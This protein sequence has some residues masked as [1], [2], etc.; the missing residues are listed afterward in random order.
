[1]TTTETPF[2]TPA[3][4]T[5]GT[6]Y[7]FGLLGQGAEETR[8]FDPT[9]GPLYPW[10]GTGVDFCPAF[11]YSSPQ[12]KLKAPCRLAITAT[13]SPLQSAGQHARLAAAANLAFWRTRPRST[14]SNRRLRPKNPMFEE[15]YYIDHEAASPPSP[16]ASS[17]INS[18]PTRSLWTDI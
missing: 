1:M 9:A 10:L 7:W 18:A 2:L 8:S 5:N 16:T 14:P 6:S 12:F 3:P 17:A 4:P 13:T 11:D 15:W